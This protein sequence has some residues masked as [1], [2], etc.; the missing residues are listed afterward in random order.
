MQETTRLLTE[1]EPETK[2]GESLYFELCNG[3]YFSDIEEYGLKVTGKI[4]QERKPSPKNPTQIQCVKEG[5][6]IICANEITVPCDLYEGDIWYPSSGKVEKYNFVG[7]HGGYGN[8][9]NWAG[10]KGVSGGFVM[11]EKRTRAKGYC[12]HSSNIGTLYEG[13]DNVWFGVESKNTY[14]TGILTI[15]GF[16]KLDNPMQAF[17]EWVELQKAN[18]TPVLLVAKLNKPIIEQYT[19]QPI[20]APK[21]TVNVNQQVIEQAAELSA[22]M[23]VKR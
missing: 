15:L 17:K 4:Y 5:T 10:T 23:L 19:P 21:G 7:E 13:S 11:P 14:W 9:Y 12:S 16:D 22:T 6:K 3:G 20:F 18:G 1:I 8:I 2:K